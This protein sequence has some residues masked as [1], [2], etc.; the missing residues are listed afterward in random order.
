MVID[1]AGFAV[2]ETEGDHT[3]LAADGFIQSEVILGS[4]NI[5]VSTKYFSMLSFISLD[6]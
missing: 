1:H 5:E 2:S 3:L 4:E 6:S